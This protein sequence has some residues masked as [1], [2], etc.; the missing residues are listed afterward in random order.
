MAKKPGKGRPKLRRGEARDVRL[1][2]VVSERVSRAI[3][4]IR[5]AVS[6]S[7]WVNRLI[8]RELDKSKT[9]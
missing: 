4:R 6:R 7:T 5:G 9:P 8:V 3:D 2:V 1:P